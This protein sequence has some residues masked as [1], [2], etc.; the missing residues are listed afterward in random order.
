MPVRFTVRGL[1][2]VVIRPAKSW[3]APLMLPLVVSVS[4]PDVTVILLV[5]RLLLL[6][7]ETDVPEALKLPV[8]TLL[9]LVSEI[10]LALEVKFDVPATEIGPFCL[11]F[12][13]F[14]TDRL[15]DSVR[16]GS[17]M[18]AVAAALTVKLRALREVFWKVNPFAPVVYV[19]KVK[20]CSESPVGPLTLTVMGP[21]MRLLKPLVILIL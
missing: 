17:V 5:I 14:V 10:A 13:P 20:S 4:A 18:S 21:E 8:N 11:I 6:V 2:L 12:P 19:Y 3:L 1:P 9:L 15:P 7:M 16:E